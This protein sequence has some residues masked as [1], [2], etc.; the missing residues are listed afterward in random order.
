MKCAVSF[1]LKKLT[2]AVKMSEEQEQA[3]LLV[4]HTIDEELTS[5]WE[6]MST[7]PYKVNNKWTS[8]F[9]LDQ[10]KTQSRLKTI[11]DLNTKEST[12]VIDSA[13]T[14]PGF[15]APLWISEAID[16]ETVQLKL[17]SDL[18]KLGD[19]MTTRQTFDIYNRR[20][21]LTNRIA[22]HRQHAA[23]FIDIMV[24]D[25]RAMPS[26]AQETDGQPEHASLY[27]PSAL[28]K[29]LATTER[30]AHVTELEKT[31]RRAE[32]L[33]ALR[34][35]RMACLQKSQM[36]IGKNKNAR[37]EVANTRAQAMLSCLTKRIS[38]ATA[39]YNVSYQALKNLGVKQAEL[40]PFQ[41]LR[42]SEF[43]G[44]MSILR[45]DRELG[46][47]S[48]RLPWFWTVRGSGEESEP[49]LRSD[50]DVDGIWVEWFYGRERYRWWQE[51]ELWLRREIASTLFT[52]KSM[53]DIWH[54]R[55]TSERA[56]WLPGYQSYC[57]CQ[58]DVFHGL[59]ESGFCRCSLV[60]KER[61][62]LKI[63][64]RAW[65]EFLPLIKDKGVDK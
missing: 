24:T 17:R 46:E 25:V 45:G 35:V 47:G 52:F 42:E 32:C 39:E 18:H 13:T 34:R 30:S 41:R 1:L 31:L 62:E 8:V 4:H 2:E 11:L 57:I 19:T 65:K 38:N 44:L 23:F 15:T 5:K 12:R 28:G 60:L 49:V 43:T 36:L 7:E 20:V 3:W 61:P 59:L 58:C 10:S 33:E 40:Q 21:S 64:M 53:A 26:L 6:S 50:E 14:E 51:E 63:C 56:K 16:I 27:L 54:E 29:K 37:G 22:M 48:R 55:S 9:L